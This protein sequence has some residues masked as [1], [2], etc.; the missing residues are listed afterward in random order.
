MV[1][2][3]PSAGS[4]IATKE[5]RRFNEFANAVRKH[6]YIGLCYGR[7]GVGK[8]LSA[9]RYARWDK[10]IDLLTNW[11]PREDSDLE[12][13]ASLARSRAV[14]FTPSVGSNFREMKKDLRHIMSR[15]DICIEQHLEAKKPD[16][17]MIMGPEY[18]KKYVQL[19]IVDEA[20]R[21]SVQSLEYLR[22]LFDQDGIG[23]ILIGMPGIEKQLSRYAQLYSRVGFSHQYRPLGNE[24][25]RFV[26]TR[27]WKNLGFG[28]EDTEFSDAQAVAAIVRIAGGS[29]RLLQRLL[30]QIERV[31]KINDL[32]TISDDVVEAARS[33]LVIGAT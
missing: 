20:E 26:L 31:L 22:D 28:L 8:T 16:K 21:L 15:V 13:Y 27:R 11:G 6:R 7:A 30:I 23:L 4:F 14:F 18:G 1:R 12:V 24:E 32:S 3:R 19:L 29:F 17:V 5:H 10:A 33:T 25:L 9:R 2:N